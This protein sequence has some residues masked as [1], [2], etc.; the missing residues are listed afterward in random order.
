MSEGRNLQFCNIMVNMDLPGNPMRVEQRIG[1]IHRIG[2]KRDVY[3]FNMALK[4]TIEE[5][6]LDRLYPTIGLFHHR[7]GKLRSL[8]SR[9]AE[10]GTSFDHDI[11]ERRV[12]ADSPA[13]LDNAFDADAADC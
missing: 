1:R 11:F 2:Q 8:L 4:D 9:L 13:A 6:V 5:Y 3:V 7:V 12:N 10:S